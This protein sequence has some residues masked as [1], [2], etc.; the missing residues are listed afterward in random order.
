MTS[1]LILGAGGQIADQA[2]DLFLQET[3]VQ[4]TLYLRNANRLKKYESNRAR[5]VEGD[6]LDHTTLRESME[7][8]DAV[9]AN[10]SG[11]DLEDQ[12]K[13]IVDAMESTGVKRLN[14]I[15][16]LG[17]YDEVPGDFGK[18]NNRTIGEYL[19]PYRKSVDVIEASNL[20]YTVLRPA[21][22]TDYDEIE[23]EVTEKGEPFKGTEVSR[24]SVAALVV[25]LIES[26]DLHVRGNLG[27][28]KP[29]TDGEKS[30]FY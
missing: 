5:L 8:Q 9:Y 24:K 12:A 26:P 11:D 16:S 14:F 21:W 15:S 23:Y 22:L 29:N 6:V 13:A 3:D 10:L 18:W 2:I 20:D 17:I 28:N 25:K 30:A 1:I 7:G 27:V 19:G 4:L